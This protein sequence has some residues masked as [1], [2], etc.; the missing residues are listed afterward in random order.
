MVDDR[1]KLRQVAWTEL[2]PWLLLGR[3]LRLATQARLLGLAAVALA[4]TV[5]GWWFFGQLFAGTSD[6]QLT[7]W[8]EAYSRGPVLS[9]SAPE[10][11]IDE[12]RKAEPGIRGPENPLVG[13]A[14]VGRP[15]QNPI[16]AA[17]YNLSGPFRQLFEPRLSLAG[18]AFL[19]LCALW[20]DL[21]WSF[22]GGVITRLVALQVTTHE[23]G[24]LPRRMRYVLRRYLSYFS[25][26]LY[27]LFGALLFIVPLAIVG[28]I[29]RTGGFGI[30]LL[31][32]LWPA[33]LVVGL[34]IT[35]F[36]VGLLFGWPL[37]WPTISTEGT[38]S[39]DALSRSYSYVFQRPLHYLWFAV[40]ASALARLGGWWCACLRWRSFT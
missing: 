23:R 33:L 30:A 32:I 14:A 1:G 36:L 8:I 15:H 26:P 31:A 27:P 22:F 13:P 3:S 11:T 19:L 39:F 24:S 2:F 34:L 38:D 17:W 40:V 16:T 10:P 18:L 12:M 6:E 35:I 25:A 5:G 20:V 9:L 7:Q 29:G 28:L 21:V 4:L 37:M